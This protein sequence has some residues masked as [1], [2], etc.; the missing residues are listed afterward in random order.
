MAEGWIKL[1]REIVDHWIWQDPFKLRAWLDLI[2][3]ANHKPKKIL[4]N[5]QLVTIDVG[6][7]W[8]SYEH[9]ATRWGC[10]KNR[11]VRFLKL[12]KD[13]EMI[14]YKSTPNGTLINVVNYRVYQ[15]FSEDSDTLMDTPTDTPTERRRIYGRT[16]NNNDKRMNKNDKNTRARKSSFQDFDQRTYDYA[17]LE[18]RLVNK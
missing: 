5:G 6:Q 18:E 11:V 1:H 8:T 14:T 9:L 12:L 16:T 3:L 2:M 7:H 10:S 15:G 4:I 13:D 17:E